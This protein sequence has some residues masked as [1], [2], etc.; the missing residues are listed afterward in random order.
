M[1][2]GPNGE[3][4]PTDAP[5][6]PTVRWRMHPYWKLIFGG[7]AAIHAVVFAATGSL[8]TVALLAL[9]TFVSLAWFWAVGFFKIKGRHVTK[10]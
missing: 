2:N 9:A 6:K 7:L 10:P 4:R 5:M 3:R 8:K 1:P